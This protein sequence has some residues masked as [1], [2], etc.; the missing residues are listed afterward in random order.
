MPSIGV[1]VL[2]LKEG[3][4][5][6]GKRTGAHGEGTYAAPGGFVECGETL[7]EALRREVREEA[8]IEVEDIRLISVSDLLLWKDRHYL[9]IGFVANWTGGEVQN[10]SGEAEGWEW[11]DPA[12]PPSPLFP[13]IPVYLEALKTGRVYRSA[14]RD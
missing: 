6:L 7:E 13:S 12:E 9:D 2:V 14:I 5:L 11:F 8:G 10:I 3:R 4:I 1:G